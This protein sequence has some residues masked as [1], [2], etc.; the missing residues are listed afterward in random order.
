ME[1]TDEEYAAATALGEEI[2]R[3][4]HAI[5]ARYDREARSAASRSA[6]TQG[7][8]C[9]ASIPRSTAAR[10]RRPN[11]PARASTSGPRRCWTERPGEGG[12]A[13][14]GSFKG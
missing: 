7:K 2:H 1:I 12:R 8:S 5:A 3:K 14:I 11:W 9:S 13:S 4:G 10:R 6:P